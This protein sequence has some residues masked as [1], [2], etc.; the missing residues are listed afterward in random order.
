MR[1]TLAT[2]FAC[3]LLAAAAL[4]FAAAEAQ[5]GR[6]ADDV[7]RPASAAE[8]TAVDR[9]L[10]QVYQRRIA[11]AR[12]DDR[13]DQR[14]RGWYSEEA[15]LRESERRWIAFRNA[16][17][18]YLTQQEVGTRRY[19]AMVRGCLVQ[20]SEERIAELRGAEV[21]LSRR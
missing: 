7:I 5:Q 9:R 3:A 10:N 15:A 17:C 16:E 2:L 14:F 1:N 21:M 8:L 13:R 19:P 20:Q 12:A 6:R 18:R 11:N 4:P